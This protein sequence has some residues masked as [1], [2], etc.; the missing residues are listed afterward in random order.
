[1]SSEV[2]ENSLE[3]L[4]LLVVD[5]PHAT[6]EW[7]ES[8][9]V[10]LRNQNIKGG[11]LDL[12][13]PSYTDEEHYLGRIRRAAPKEGDIVITREAPMGEV[14][15]IPAGLKCCLGQRQV[16]L[17]PDPQKVCSR[18]L[19]YALQ[20]PYLQRQISWNEG[21]GSTVSNLRIPVL[22]A[23]NVPTP[24]LATQKEVSAILGSLDD[25]I[26]ILRETNATLESMAQAIF[27]SW[28]VDFDPVRAKAEGRQPERMDAET[29]ALFPDSFEESEL[30]VVP[31][32]WS[33][34]TLSD[35]SL[36]NPESWSAKSHPET[37]AYVDL[38]NAKENVVGEITEYNF[39]DAPSRA[40]RVLRNGDT[41]V[42]TVRPGNR[43][44]ALISYAS[45]S[46]TGSTGFAVLRPKQKE[47]TEFVYLA[48][49]ADCSIEYLAHVADG[50]A[51]PAV[52][53]E[54]VAN[55]PCLVPGEHILRAFHETVKP[56]FE[57]VGSNN[58]QTQTLSQL[59]DTLLP[60]LI[61]GE[62]RL[63]ETESIISDAVSA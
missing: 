10:V 29:A 1:M 54:V 49:T 21:T 26:T 8:G 11:R 47:N 4:C 32:G 24:A 25:C 16:L 50:A 61:S 14:C 38:A 3:S 56:M 36:L 51:Y 62:I 41:I 31:K 9:V 55:L 35:L 63:P 7:T 15:Q 52:R 6:P 53:P 22:K 45:A 12:R 17:R 46:L 23:L 40:R 27:K 2:I 5:C 19:L 37:I 59:R 18:F 33:V 30:R 44:F 13:A 20:S 58:Q 34:G 57:E 28:F 60:K 39:D 42:G 48:A 43:S